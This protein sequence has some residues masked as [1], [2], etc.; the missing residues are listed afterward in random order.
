MKLAQRSGLIAMP[1][2]AQAA[3][4]QRGWRAG[5]LAIGAM[6]LLVG[7]VPI[8]LLLVRRPEDLGCCPTARRRRR[9]AV[10]AAHRARRRPEPAFSRRQALGTGAFWLLLLYTVLVYPVQAGV[11]LHQAPFLIE[12]G[13]DPT[14][15][16]TD[17]QHLF[18]DLGGGDPGLRALPRGVPIR[19]PLARPARS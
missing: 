17:R 3:I 12:R 9:A 6:T 10:P 19:Y 16:A 11:S 15:A 13:I 4:A 18:A 1:L 5:W 8:W 7:F 14:I 2:F